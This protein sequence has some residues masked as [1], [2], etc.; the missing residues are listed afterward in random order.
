MQ[1]QPQQ[2]DI[3]YYANRQG[4]N[5]FTTIILIF[6]HIGAIGAL[7]CFTWGRLAAAVVAVLLRHR[8]RHQHGLSSPAHPSVL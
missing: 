7:F 8:A 5:V 1:K 2:L 3:E 6:L 4:L